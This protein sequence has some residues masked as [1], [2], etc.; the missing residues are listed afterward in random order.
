VSPLKNTLGHW[1]VTL[2]NIL[3]WG[4]I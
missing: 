1:L 3:Y 4:N 2:L